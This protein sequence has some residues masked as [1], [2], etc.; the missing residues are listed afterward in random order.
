MIT[1]VVLGYNRVNEVLITV[2]KLKAY[3]KKLPFQLDIIVVDNASVDE[4]TAQVQSVHSDIK[5]ITKEINNGI[6]GWNDGF[7]KV[8]SK[9]IL[10][11][12]DDSH[13]EYGI[14][15]AVEYLEGSPKT[16]ILALNITS[17]PYLTDG[18]VWKTGKPWQHEEEILGF[19][20]CGAIIR[21]EVYDKIG[22]FAEWMQVYGH[23][24]EYGIRCID[25]GY[26]IRYFKNSS[27]NHRA[28]NIN[29]SLR[30]ARVFGTR[31]E[32]GIAYKFLGKDRWKV[33]IRMFFNNLKRIRYEGILSL[34][35]DVIGA[36][37]FWR[38]RHN[39]T[40]EPLSVQ[41]QEFFVKNYMNTNPF[42]SFITKHFKR[43]VKN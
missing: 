2:D 31:N 29:R 6:A 28:S 39:L 8:T 11:L 17:G 36:L 9:Y 19:F 20:G 23:E 22:G 12:D 32:M 10:V 4:T 16:G 38:F 33:I 13:P 37:E 3:A 40:H 42:F 26:K 25:A 27:I 35:Y 14:A 24:W 1:A 43:P 18:W 30:R 41:A 15:E 21:K 5:L 7:A 34:Y